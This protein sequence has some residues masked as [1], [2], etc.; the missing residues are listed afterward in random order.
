MNAARLLFLFALI[1]SAHVAPATGDEW[2]MINAKYQ[3]PKHELAAVRAAALDG[4]GDSAQRLYKHFSMFALD[5]KE[6][7]FWAQISAENGN[8]QGQHAYGFM[9]LQQKSEKSR[10]RAVY[11]IRLA[12]GQG[13]SASQELL[14]SIRAG[15]PVP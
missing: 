8:P 1:L 10:A 14:D 6:A 9:L 7:F 2:S 3:I 11:W 5:E 12:A 15:K 4:S 13:V